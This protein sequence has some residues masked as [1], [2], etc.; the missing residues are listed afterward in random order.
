MEAIKRIEQEMMKKGISKLKLSKLS[1]VKRSTIYNIFNGNVEIK[2]EA[3]RK[4]SKVLNVSLDYLVFGTEKK[5]TVH[6]M[7]QLYNELTPLGQAKV[8]AYAEGILTTEKRR[9]TN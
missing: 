1:G 6:H 5:P 3:L 8:E 7:L 4:I 9:V 2:I